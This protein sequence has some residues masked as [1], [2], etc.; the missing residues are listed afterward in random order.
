MNV[1]MR[2]SSR[3]GRP[4]SLFRTLGKILFLRLEMRPFRHGFDLLPHE[5]F[6]LIGRLGIR[7]AF[8]VV[9]ATVVEDEPGVF[10]KVLGGGI[11][12]SL[13]L[14]LHGAKIHG[15]LNHVVVVRNIIAINRDKEGPCRVMVLEVIEQVE[16]LVVVGSVAWLASKL[17]HIRRPSGGPDGGDIEGVDLLDAIF[18]L[19]WGRVDVVRLGVGSN[20]GLD[21]FLL[22]KEHAAHFQISNARQHGALHNRSALVIFNV[23]HPDVLGES[24]FLGEAL[25]LEIANRIVVGICQEVHDVA[26]GLYIVFQVG[27]EM[28]AV[29]LDLLV[30]TDGA[31]DDF[32]KLAAFKGSVGDAADDFEGL[33]DDGDGQ[34]GSIVDESRNVVLGHF[35]ELLL[36]DALEAGE[37]DERFALVVVVD[38]AEFDF[39][40]ALLEDGGLDKR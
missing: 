22:L 9:F 5:S 31:K 30:G 16:E 39:A 34:M 38:Y 29:S 33:L 1:C 7:R 21:A 11:L 10:D 37:D 24:D 35:G 15:L 3:K 25:F 23:S 18:P 2:W 36:E 27:H 40:I 32:G 20:L 26:G 13:E 8:V 17:V 14:A 12:V 6:Q 28:R 4:C 19:L